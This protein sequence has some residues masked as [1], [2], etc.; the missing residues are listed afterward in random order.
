MH[1]GETAVSFQDGL[2]R[3]PH[4]G[5]MRLIKRVVIATDTHIHCVASDHN[6]N[7][8]PLRLNGTLFSVTLVELGAQAAAVH[9]SL[10]NIANNH[11]GLLIGLKK[12]EFTKN[13]VGETSQNLDIYADQIHFDAD[14][15]LYSFCV[16]S[17]EQEIVK[18]QAMLQMKVENE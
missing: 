14:V 4:Q 17:E 18:G 13:V 1:Q 16:R 11:T 9:T 7:D 6:V 10:Y 2:N 5:A 3:M 12:V 15:A 8:Y